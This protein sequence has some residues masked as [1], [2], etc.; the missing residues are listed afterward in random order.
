MI[1]GSSDSV[2]ILPGE[3]GVPISLGGSIFVFVHVYSFSWT[4]GCRFCFINYHGSCCE[5]VFHA[6]RIR[7]NPSYFI[8]LSLCA[9]HSLF[10]LSI[11]LLSTLTRCTVFTTG[12]YWA[13]V[14]NNCYVLNFHVVKIKSYIKE[15]VINLYSKAHQRHA[16]GGGTF[17]HKKTNVL[18]Q[19]MKP[20]MLKSWAGFPLAHPGT[21]LPV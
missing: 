2:N 7:K 18:A 19:N 4:L 1:L 20:F 13:E 14:Y 11:S 5:C 6:F 17:Y 9:C 10:I 8:L 15:S 16:K 12:R 3:G 21:I